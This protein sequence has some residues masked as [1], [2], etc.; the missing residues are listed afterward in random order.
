[1]RNCKAPCKYVYRG[2]RACPYVDV[3]SFLTSWI[4]NGTR[5]NKRSY[6]CLFTIIFHV[7]RIIRSKSTHASYI[8][9]NW[10]CRL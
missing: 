10:N 6:E 8:S 3:K 5:Q 2:G 9:L 1:M 7:N 4:V